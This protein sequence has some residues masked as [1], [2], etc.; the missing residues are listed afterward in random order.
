MAKLSPLFNDAQLID[1]IPASGG[2]LFTYAAGSS[3]K[4]TTYK[5]EDSAVAQANPIVLNARGEPDSPIWLTEGLSYKFVFAPADDTDPPASPIRTIDDVTGTNDA[6]IDISQWID[7][8][9]TP[10]YVNATQ[11]TVPGDQTSVLTVNRRVK[12]TVTA[13]TVYGYISVSAYT[14]LTTV[15]VVL[16]SGTLDVGLS[17]VQYGILTP[18]NSSVPNTIAPVASPAFTGNPTAPTPSPGDD[19][20][21]IAT[22]E[23]V[24]DAISTA[25]G[26]VDVSK[27]PVRQTVLSGA[28]D[29]SGLPSFGGSTG[30]TT[31][32]AST[33]LIATAANGFAST[34]GVDRIG[35]IENPS[36]TGLS[37]N[38]T[39]YLYLDIASD[40]SCTTGSTTLAPT[41]RWGGADVTTNNQFTFNIQEMVGKVGNGSVATQ[42]YRVFV[43]EV[44]VSS[45]VVASITW[46]AVMG[47]YDSGFTSTLVSAGASYTANHNIG[48]QYIDYKEVIEC[49]TN[50][51][52]YVVGD[53]LVDL[54]GLIGGSTDA[55]KPGVVNTY[56]T[57]TMRRPSNTNY[58]ATN[59]STGASATL[60]ASSWKYK[61]LAERKF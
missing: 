3:T 13:G 51:G 35:S 11:F 5:D 16:D 28:L 18:D 49:T 37:T 20:T 32:T 2:L 29:S 21:S 34:G 46:Y 1:G 14:S 53:Q 30:S 8:G 6:S 47:R 48:T 24:T 7:S 36:W 33:T 40:G 52:T 25:I 27:L 43:G 42:T 59:M 17:A 10:T 23:F 38:G 60:T 57:I 19:D 41:Y 45:N 55:R 4:Q 61:I 58:I 22:T 56:K 39:M 44:T 9:F 50:D 31:V 26:L 12:L 15:T 54:L